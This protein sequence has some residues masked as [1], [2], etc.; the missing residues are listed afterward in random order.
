MGRIK[1]HTIRCKL[2]EV[3]TTI[4][5]EEA[6]LEVLN[7]TKEIISQDFS[8]VKVILPFYNS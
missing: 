2:K 6:N 3:G 4:N 8:K 7:L 1:S 5:M